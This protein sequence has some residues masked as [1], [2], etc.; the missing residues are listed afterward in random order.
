MVGAARFE[1]ATSCTPSKR[2][3]RLSHAPTILFP[4]TRDLPDREARRDALSVPRMRDTPDYTVSYHSRPSRP[5][6]AS[7]RSISPAH[8][9]H[10]RLYC[11][12]PLAT[13]PTAKRVGTLYQSRACGTRPDYTISYHSRPSRPRS[14]SGRSTSPAHAGHAPTKL[15]PTTRDLPDREAR[16]DALPVPRMRDTPDYTISYHS[17]SSRPRSASGRSTSPDTL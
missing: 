14:A 6:S 9:G 17:R 12:L 10:A 16:R 15:F 13:F 7:G 4:T 3:T 5:R 8:A 1:L 2:S 11:F